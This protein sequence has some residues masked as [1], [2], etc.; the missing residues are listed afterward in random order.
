MGHTSSSRMREP[1]PLVRCVRISAQVSI[2]SCPVRKTRMSPGTGWEMCAC[3]T[4][5][6]RTKRGG[7]GLGCGRK[8]FASFLLAFDNLDKGE[9]G[10]WGLA[11]LN[12]I[13]TTVQGK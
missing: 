13:E 1:R 6:R 8:Q 5:W 11:A 7:W 4:R 9:E 12:R 2:S 3:S 10:A